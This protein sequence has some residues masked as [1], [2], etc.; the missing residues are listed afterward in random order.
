PVEQLPAL[1]LDADVGGEAL[2]LALGEVLEQFGAGG[3]EAGGVTRGQQHVG[4][5]A[6]QLSRD[7][8]ADAGAAAGDKCELA[9]EPPAPGIHACSYRGPRRAGA[10]SRPA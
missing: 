6:E 1:L 3:V 5:E 2:H 7:R 8:A 4:A 9:V 10:V